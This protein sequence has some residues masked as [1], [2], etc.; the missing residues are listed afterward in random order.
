MQGETLKDMENEKY[1]MCD[2]IMARKLKKLESNRK[3]LQDLEYC[4]KHS[5][6]WRIRNAHSW[7]W[8]IEKNEKR[9]K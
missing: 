1:R 2:L 5:K 4:E 7:T 3:T 8:T 9:G 6:T